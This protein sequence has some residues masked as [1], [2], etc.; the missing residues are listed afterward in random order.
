MGERYDI[1]LVQE[2]VRGDEYRVFVF[3]EEAVFSYRKQRGA[4]VGDGKHAVAELIA[5]LSAEL[6]GHGLDPIDP[7]SKTLVDAMERHQLSM[8][9]VLPGGFSLEVGARANLSAGGSPAEFTT[10]VP[11]LLAETG[12]RATKALGLMVAGV[13]IILP[14]EPTQIPVVIEVNSN[15]AVTSLEKVDRLDVALSIFGKMFKRLLPQK[16][17]YE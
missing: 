7:K 3:G 9:S 6:V 16:A 2:Y 10:K 12:I 8:H 1:G 17:H 14:K 4:I 15:P 11:R 5:R 13:D